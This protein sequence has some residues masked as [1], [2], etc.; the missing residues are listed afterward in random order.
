MHDF[1]KYK[2]TGKEKMIY[3]LLEEKLNRIIEILE[4][5]GSVKPG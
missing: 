4:R 3:E 1:E 2:M 5:Q